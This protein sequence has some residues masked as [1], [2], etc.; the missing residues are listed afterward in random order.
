ME[1]VKRWRH[2]TFCTCNHVKAELKLKVS[3][4]TR[5]RKISVSFPFRLQYIKLFIWMLFGTVV[6]F[7]SAVPVHKIRHGC[8]HSSRESREKREDSRGIWGE[9]IFLKYGG[10]CVVHV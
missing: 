2:K 9:S 6:D 4:R 1:Y 5:D 3:K 10:M 7:V 8:Q